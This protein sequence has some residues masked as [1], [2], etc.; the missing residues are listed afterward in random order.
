MGSAFRTWFNQIPG[1]DPIE[2][3]QAGVMQ[4]ILLALMVGIPISLSDPLV[5]LIDIVVLGL[6]AVAQRAQRRGAFRLGV[7]LAVGVMIVAIGLSMQAHSQQSCS[8]AHQTKFVAFHCA[9]SLA[10]NPKLR[11]YGSLFLSFGATS[12][13]DCLIT[14]ALDSADVGNGPGR[15]SHY[16]IRR[17]VRSGWW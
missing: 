4:A 8:G 17:A 14:G 3:Q 13:S 2:Q 15:Q 6:L 5:T 10:T 11:L 16:S 1:N 7:R 9:V 12:T